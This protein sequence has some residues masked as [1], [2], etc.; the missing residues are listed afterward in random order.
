[1]AEKQNFFGNQNMVMQKN[2]VVD[3][4]NLGVHEEWEVGLVAD[5]DL[6][7][8]AKTFTVPSGQEWEIW[9]VWAEFTSVTGSTRQLAIDIL[10]TEDN[11][12]GRCLAGTA[13]AAS[14]AYKYYFGLNVDQMYGVLANYYQ[15]RL[16]F[17][18]VSAG[19]TIRVWDANECGV[20]A[21]DLIVRM[22][23]LFRYV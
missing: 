4:Y 14:L 19:E 18:R 10:D 12:I 3:A 17:M 13:Q 8:S 11:V 6:N 21:D 20:D 9:G 2:P 22:K 23:Y 15:D 1:M 16:I 5:T 7:N